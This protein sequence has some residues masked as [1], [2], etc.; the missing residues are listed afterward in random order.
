MFS[1]L[2]LTKKNKLSSGVTL[3]ELMVVV[4]VIGMLAGT[5]L[6]V[7]NKQRPQEAGRD[8]IKVSR[9]EGF[10]EAVESYRTLVGSYPTS[11]TASNCS[12]LANYVAPNIMTQMFDDGFVYTGGGG[13][14]FRVT[15]PA[16]V[17]GFYVYDSSWPARVMLCPA[18]A[19]SLGACSSLT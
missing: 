14:S 3:I 15:I 13:T 11:C 6:F 9:L 7:I 1:A 10:A 19:S 16:S 2:T 8:A 4:A 18:A 17:G 5:L 12:S